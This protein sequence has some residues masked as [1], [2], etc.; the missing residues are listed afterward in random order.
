MT[1]LK[2][3]LSK[4]YF[5]RELPA[6]FNTISLGEAIDNHIDDLPDLFHTGS[7][8]SNPSVHNSA[9]PGTLRRRLS[10]PNPINMFRLSKAINNNWTDIEPHIQ[11]STISMTTPMLGDGNR[12]IDRKHSLGQLPELIAG[13]RSK[14]KYILKADISRFY[15]SIYTHSIPWALHSK[16]VAKANNSDELF[17]NLLDKEVRNS[18]DRQT[19]GIP[20][21]PDTS[22]VLAESILSC[23]DAELEDR[24]SINGLRYIDDYQLGFNTIGDAEEVMAYLQESLSDYELALNPLKTEIIE[25]PN[26][27]E[28]LA[29]SDL[30]AYTVRSSVCEQRSDLMRYFNKAFF[31]ASLAPRKSVV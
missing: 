19:V 27:F 28:S 1:V 14:S 16:S 9:R 6:P 23:I 13:V 25:L 29:I 22:L 18:Q 8:I 10:I 24:F 20:I 3:L 26:K 4:G 21:G 17:G 7:H 11:R 30:R 31:E 12:A 2:E 5:P 15:P